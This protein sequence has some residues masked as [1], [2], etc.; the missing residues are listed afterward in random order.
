METLINDQLTFA[1]VDVIPTPLDAASAAL[2]VQV[3]QTLHQH[4]AKDVLTKL[5]VVGCTNKVSI[6]QLPEEDRKKLVMACAIKETSATLQDVSICVT[7]GVADSTAA[8]FI[9]GYASSRL[10]SFVAPTPG[11]FYPITPTTNKKYVFVASSKGAVDPVT[12]RLLH[13]TGPVSVRYFT[14]SPQHQPQQTADWY[15]KMCGPRPI[16]WSDEQKTCAQHIFPPTVTALLQKLPQPHTTVTLNPGDTLVMAAGTPLQFETQDTAIFHSVSFCRVPEG[17]P[18]MESAVSEW[19]QLH[20]LRG[21]CDPGPDFRGGHAFF[22]VKGLPQFTGQAAFPADAELEFKVDVNALQTAQPSKITP[23]EEALLF[24]IGVVRKFIDALKRMSPGLW[25]VEFEQKHKEHLDD[26]LAYFLAPEGK[27]KSIPKTSTVRS[28]LKTLCDTIEKLAS[29]ALHFNKWVP[30]FEAVVPKMA[31][32]KFAHGTDLEA[33]RKEVARQIKEIQ[34]AGAWPKIYQ[35]GK[36]APLQTIV[37]E[38]ERLIKE[39]PNKWPQNPK[40]WLEHKRR[41]LVDFR[42]EIAIPHHLVDDLE[43][44]IDEADPENTD[45]LLVIDRSFYELN[46]LFDPKCGPYVH[47]L[48][49]AAAAS[50]DDTTTTKKKKRSRSVSPEEINSNNDDNDEDSGSIAIGD[51]DDSE[52]PLGT[53]SRDIIADKWDGKPGSGKVACKSCGEKGVLLTSKYCMDCATDDL[54]TLIFQSLSAGLI[55][56]QKKTND[57]NDEA[58]SQIKSRIKE[59]QK[60]EKNNTHIFG[61]GHSRSEQAKLFKE[62]LDGFAALERDFAHKDIILAEHEDAQDLEEYGDAS[63]M[64][65][66]GDEDEDEEEEEEEEEAEFSSSSES[67]D[68][69]RHSKKKKTA[70]SSDDAASLALELLKFKRERGD[71]ITHQEEMEDL[72]LVGDEK[73][74]AAARVLLDKLKSLPNQWAVDVYDVEAKTTQLCDTLGWFPSEKE[75]TKALTVHVALHAHLKGKATFSVREKKNSL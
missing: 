51:D 7:S 15:D 21:I 63:A 69:R 39:D 64:S 28:A 25:S 5:A 60:K 61:S 17:N 14:P 19:L 67:Y 59:L 68:K 38:V 40:E 11:V 1:P 20:R 41:G 33:R 42:G 27:I 65:M 55:V 70:S 58:L 74:V 54:H 36:E 62:L 26:W 75:A 24:W 50:V 45:Q 8:A 57:D 71:F 2:G 49:A 22:P 56:L 6:K 52:M 66:S 43:R 37:E 4:P 48:A 10:K 13:A 3:A 16:W 18:N 9:A 44:V 73:S 23:T 53:V 47:P 30:R 12:L 29:R 34:K 72:C 32:L 31:L 46:H 35:H